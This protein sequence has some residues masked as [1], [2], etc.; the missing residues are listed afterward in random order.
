MK[1]SRTRRVGLDDPAAADY[2]VA[3]VEDGG[4]AGGDGALGLVEGGEDFDLVDW[5][6]PEGLPPPN[7]GTGGPNPDLG[8]EP[9][10]AWPR[11]A[12]GDGGS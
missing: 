3:V 1:E 4:L 5:R 12:R 8:W 10:R 11:R 2:F 9:A 7:E 6:P